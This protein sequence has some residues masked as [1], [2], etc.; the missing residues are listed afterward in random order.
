MTHWRGNSTVALLPLVFRRLAV[1]FAATLTHIM[2]AGWATVAVS[3][4][5]KDLI[6]LLHNLLFLHRAG[7]EQVNNF[8]VLLK[9]SRLEL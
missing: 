4:S 8:L 1:L 7:L 3:S 6:S 9:S 2:M 5:K